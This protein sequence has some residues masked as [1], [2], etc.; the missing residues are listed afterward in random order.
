MG[1]KLVD[2]RT[3][4]PMRAR[5]IL[6]SGLATV[7]AILST[8][9]I[10][11]LIFFR[12]DV[13]LGIFWLGPGAGSS[14]YPALLFQ[15]GDADAFGSEVPLQH[16]ESAKGLLNS[17]RDYLEDRKGR[18][19]IVYLCA[20]GTEAESGA[21]LATP[22]IF[23]G[24]LPKASDLDQIE[25]KS[26]IE[27]FKKHPG[28]RFLILDLGRI[29]TNRDLGVF[30]DDLVKAVKDLV[31]GDPAEFKKPEW[32]GFSIFCACA[33]GQWSWTSDAD[34]R[35]VFGHYVV[36]AL[37]RGREA[38]TVL[39]NRQ[40]V[41]WVTSKVS[42]WV[43]RHRNH[44]TQTPIVYGDTN[45]RLPFPRGLVGAGEDAS[46]DDL[47]GVLKKLN[48]LWALHKEY[49]RQGLFVLDPFHWRDFR[50]ALLRAERFMRA[51]LQTE[52]SL[53]LEDAEAA[54]KALRAV[55]EK[56][57]F[58]SLAL[59]L[60]AT[61][62]PER[63]KE[64]VAQG[65]TFSALLA[66]RREKPPAPASPPANP[67]PPD[68]PTLAEV[69][70]KEVNPLAPYA[71]S[72]LI[73]WSHKFIGQLKAVKTG[74]DT[75][76]WRDGPNARMM[77]EA[78]RVRK[79]AEE[80][81]SASWQ[82]HPWVRSLVEKG[83]SERRQAQDQ[84]FAS[85][86]H[87][88]EIRKKLLA[89]TGY[90]D[91]AKRCA[92]AIVLSRK[93]EADLPFLGDW[94]VRDNALNRVKRLNIE[95]LESIVKDARELNGLLE[96]AMKSASREPAKELG[97]KTFELNGSFKNLARKHQE[98]WSQ[99]H[100]SKDWRAID[101]V[102]IVPGMDAAEREKL[103]NL[104]R[105]LGEAEDV[106]LRPPQPTK[107]ELAKAQ[108]KGDLV[109]DAL[110]R[111]LTFQSLAE[112]W[113]RQRYGDP[114][115]EWKAGAS[116]RKVPDE[117]Y[118]LTAS[119][120]AVL[121]WCLLSIGGGEGIA[122]KLDELKAEALKEAGPRSL[123]VPIRA[124]RLS[125]AES[126]SINTENLNEPAPDLVWA[127]ER[128]RL[129]LPAWYDQATARKFAEEAVQIRLSDLFAWHAQRLLE[130]LD[131]E[132]ADRYLEAI[133][134]SGQNREGYRT[135]RDRLAQ[136]QDLEQVRF[137]HLSHAEIK[138]GEG[139]SSE[140]LEFRPRMSVRLPVGQTAFLMGNT[141]ANKLSIRKD[142]NI[143]INWGTE[144][145]DIGGKNDDSKIA[146]Y[147]FREDPMNEI[148]LRVTLTPLAFYRGHVFRAIP[149]SIALSLLATRQAYAL[150]FKSFGLKNSPVQKKRKSLKDQFENHPTECYLHDRSNHTISLEITYRP[151]DPK[152]RLRRVTV[153]A[154]LKGAAIKIKELEDPI[155]LDA[156][157]KV[158]V[159]LR[160]AT[161]NS[162]DFNEEGSPLE[163]T[164]KTFPEGD[165]VNKGTL[166]IKHTPTALW[167]DAEAWVEKGL[168]TVHISRR[169][170]DPIAVEETCFAKVAG[171]QL[172]GIRHSNSKLNDFEPKEPK[173][174]LLHG[175]WAEFVFSTGGGGEYKFSEGLIGATAGVNAGL[176]VKV[177]GFARVEPPVSGAPVPVA[178]APGGIAPTAAPF[179]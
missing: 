47:Q 44:A 113:R 17:L 159:E 102:L 115:S 34:G 71:E 28:R 52:A 9:L 63:R 24:I 29:G 38:G 87:S 121:E 118:E 43:D 33:P 112:R 91:Q 162:E 164:M 147:A 143:P 144:L 31:P 125:L 127:L 175:E 69:L 88:E 18:P 155:L 163:V 7:T 86:D 137:E 8:W 122:S 114:N 138:F 141:D 123:T 130:D 133:P 84:L 64:F 178:P 23:S 75:K 1:W 72:Q 100:S 158:P 151:R 98:K 13:K 80:A 21:V 140:M 136:L 94:Y 74:L 106:V 32:R 55:G 156:D 120:M 152:E 110:A 146:A 16:K 128:A 177:H 27:E 97:K 111:R 108:G 73:D 149:D 60:R 171:G 172:M 10:I 49:D 12:A 134:K 57:P 77:A 70:D 90:Y 104:S 116:P 107:E 168:V 36:E 40:L 50:L 179:P 46:K 22:D 150:R 126:R 169:S 170:D 103:V 67:P 58:P 25:L 56:A 95:P 105:K 39:D 173:S 129:A 53:A 157:K 19:S 142:P 165:V 42:R 81:A 85:D 89:A 132:R 14:R 167:Y 54:E 131:R 41:A 92:E 124:L 61:Y 6:A 2:V 4:P 117:A 109:S 176:K 93:V 48:E 101:N 139:K 161:V 65:E 76:A 148:D 83:D 79:L 135:V 119:G 160:L 35:S 145:F 51:E 30:G 11:W 26:V 15:K 82:P 174:W 59:T 153:T 78:M 154:T 5:I 99:A 96:S 62:D 37:G 66:P 68:P 3:S 20:A 45:L 166:K